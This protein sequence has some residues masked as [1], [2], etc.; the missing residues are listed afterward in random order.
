MAVQNSLSPTVDILNQDTGKVITH[1]SENADRVVNLSQT[2]IVRINASPET[3]NFY[4]RQGN[5]L[6]VHMKD[7]TTVRYQNF[8]HLDAEGQHSELIF[9]D[10]KGVHHALFPFAS[11]AGPAVAEAIT[12]TM[13]DTTLG[14]LT[15]AEGLTTLQALGGIAAIGGI[16][17]VA[18]AA[19]NSG[20]GGGGNDDNN[21]GGD[22]GGGDNGGGD[23]G[24]GDN[25]GGD[26]GGGDNGGGETPDPAEIALDP[27]TDDNI[28]NGSEVLQNQVISGTVDAA[29]AGR[30]ITVTLNGN[31][32]TGVVGADGSWSVT[33]PASALQAL[34]QGLNTITVTLVDVNGNTVTQT[35]DINV[36][37]VAPTLQLT[38]F[39][40]GVL[41]GEQAS[42]TQILRGSTGVAEEGQTVTVTLNGKTYTATVGADGSWQAAIPSADLLALQNG[43]QY[44]L[45]VSIT[46]LAGNTTTSE[47]RFTVNFDR[48]VLA[49]DDFTGDNVLNGS[50]LATDQILSGTTQ[51]IAAGTVVTVTLNGQNYYATVGGDGS[52]QVTI[53]S[54]DLQALANGSAT[55]TVSVP[56]GTGA[57][58]TVTDTLT[59]D[60]TVPSV[61][62]AILSTD[63]YLNAAEAT[64]PLE[65]RGFTTVTGPGAQVT[66]TFNDKTYTAV[67]DSAGNWS[68]LIPPADLATLPDGPR[69]VTATVT[70]GSTTATTD[71]VINVEINDLPAPTIVTPFGD[72]ALSAADLQQNQT[73]SG[74]TGVSGSG[75]TVTVQIGNQ[76]YTT[77][78]GTDGGWSVTIP[79]S[80]LQALPPGQTPIVVTATD[81]AGNSASATSS[82]NIDTTPPALSLYAVTDDGKLNAQ[83]LT[84]SQVLSGNSSEAGQTVTVTLNGK[85]YTTTTGSDGNWQVTLPAA[86]LGNL[87]PGAN[88]IVVTTTDAAGNTAQITDSLNVKTA[89]PSVTVTPFT[90]DNALDAAEIKTAQPLQGSVTNAEPGS[91]VTV[92]IGAWNTTATV[93]AAGNWRVDVPAVVLQGLANGDNNIQVSVTDTWNQT[94]T[95]QAP[96]TV[97]TAA[98]GVAI[99]IIADDDFINRT[100]AD[101]PL[102]I[103]G[104]SAG[105]PANTE[106][107]VTLNGITYTATVDANGNWQTTVPAADLQGLADGNYEVTATAQQGGVSDSHTLTVIINNLPDT[108]IDPLFT[109]GTLSQAEAGVDQVLT[110]S[111]GVAGAGQSVT[112]T[113]NGQAYQG[114]VDA[115]GNWSVT[116][117]SGALDSLTGN[118]SPVPLQIVVRDAAGNSQTTTTDFIVDVDAPTLTINPFAQDDALNITE[119]GQAQAFSGVATGA[120]QGD[121]IVV[122][123]NGK[124]YNTTV[125]GANG[126]WSVNIPAADLQAL[127]N[128]QAQFSVTVTDAA[129]NTSTA[130]K[131][132]TVAVDPARA[133]LLTIEPVGGDGVIDAGER[134]SGVTL[135]GTT[136]NVT[137]GQTVTITLGDDTFTGVV[138]SAGRW[139]VN[140]PADALAGLANGTYT[141]TAVV[142]DAAGN[143]VSLD[144]GFSVNTDISALTVSPVTGDNRVSLDDIAGGLVLSGSSVNFAPQ[145]TLTITLNGK[146]YTATTGADGSWSVT[147]PRADAL[148]ISDGKATL[149]V[150]GTD[151]N[152][153]VIS[154]SQSFT[155]ITT[156]L[157]EV[158]L[159][160]PFT[161]GIISAAEVSAGGAL[162]G[163]T[164]VT[165]AGQTVTVQ[166]GGNTYNAV[167]DSSGNW[168]V[169]LPPSALQGLTEGTTP[170]VVTATDAVGNQ[171]TSQSTVTVDLTAPVLTV[172]D[173]TADNIV[174][175]TEAAQPLTI[176][177]SA[178]PYDPQ[179]PQTV[180]VQIGGQS[181]SALVQ[182][183]GTWSVTL[184][185]GALTTLPDGPVSVTA[186]VSDAAGNTSSEKVS[187]TLDASQANAP[188]VAVNT[189]ATDNFI[190]ATE[191]QSPLQITGTTTRVEPG[192]TVTV[193]LNGQTYT[194]EVQPNGTWSVAVPA[195]ALAQVADGQQT[196]GVT[197]TD[198]SGNQAFVQYPVTFAAQPGSQPQVTLNAIAGDDIINSQ[199]SGQPLD[200][201]GTST[202]LAPGT[203]VS[204]VFNN[205]TYTGT[206]GANGQWSV[207][208]PASA[209]AGLQDGAYTVTATARDAAQNTATDSSSV[210]V[211]T[212]TPA[213]DING[214]S[215][216]DDAILN[217][218]E[219][220]TD[221]TLG[222]TTTAGATVQLVVGTQTLTTV[223]GTDGTWSITIPAAQ[224]QA[225]DNGPQDLTLTVTTPTGNT[226]TVPLPVTVGNDTV[227]TLAIGTVFTDGLINLSEIQNGGVISGT[228]TGLPEGTSIAITL[229]GITLNG[230]VGAGGAWQITAGADA[231]DALQ[232][233]QYTLTVTAQDQYGNP[234]TAGVAVDV[235]RTPPTA[236]VPDL[237]FGDGTVNQSEAA[238]GQQLTGTTG[239]TGAGQTVQISI[240]GGQPITGTVDNNGN[241]TVSLTPAQ[242]S[243]LADG[244]HT[245]SVTVSDRAGN[246]ATSPEATFTVYADP[247][248]TP[249]VTEP[250]TNGVLNA[251]EAAAGATLNGTTGLPADRIG[252]VMVSLNN[253]AMVQATVDADGNWSLPLTPA[254]LQA[255]PDGTIPITVI[256]TDT[257]GNTNTGTTSFDARINAVP[258]ATLNTPFIDGA[259]NNAEAGVAQTITGSTGVSGAGQ[260]VEI[261]LNGT[262]YTGAVLE[263]GDWS[264]SLPPSAFTGLT[265]GST[266]N[267]Q[268]NV[269]D[270]YGNTDSAPGSFQVETQLPT[271]AATTLFGDNAILNISEANGPLTLT[272]TTGVTGDNQYVTVTIDVNGTT[273]VANVD[274]AG[275]WSLPLPAGALSGLSPGQ[276]TLTIVAQDNFGNSQE[277]EVPFQA[278][279]TPPQVALT[280]PLFGDGYVNIAEAGAASTISGTLTSDLPNGSQ[281]SVT[282]GNKT[283]GPDRVTVTGNTWTLSLTAADW[284][285]VPNGLQS[286]NVSLTDGAGNT[287]TTTAPLYVS[288][289]AP[290]LTIDAPFGG[291]GLSG[292]ES[293]QTQT[294]TGTV[295]NV[296]P[297]QTITVTLAGQTFT[298][299]V[300]NGN[301]WSLQLSP[302]QLA[303]LANGPEQITATVTDKAG[304]VASA[305]AVN[306]DIDTTPPAVA[307]AINP[308]A[309]D[310]IINAG[311]LGDAVTISGTTLGGVSQ[312]TVQINGTAVGT[313]TVQPDGSWS[314]DVPA[315]Q[316]PNQGNYTI[317]ATTDGGT[318]ATTNVTVT[319]DTVPP[320][321]TVG[322]IAGDNVIDASEASQPLVLNGTAS[323]SEAGRQVT[324]TFNG[325][326]YYAVVGADG[327]WSVTVPQ[328]A[329]NGLSDGTYPVTATLTDA[330]GNVDTDTRNITLDTTGPLLT[331]DAAGVPAVLNTVN[332]AGG[333]LLQGTGEPGQTVTL[334]LGPLTETATVD[335]NGNWQYTFPQLDLT[336]LTDGAQ[337]INISS[338]D[339]QGNTSTNNVALNVALNKG[340]G[341]LVDDLFGGD[342]ILN[343]AE[344]LV[345]QTLTGQ[346]SGD[347]RGA[348]VT[349]TLVGTDVNIPLNAL[350]GG[351]GRISV[352]FPPSLWQGIVDNT[353]QVQLNVTDA[354]GN[355]TNKI[356]DIN[357]ALTDVPVVSQVLVGTDN[358]IN[359]AESTVN[360]TI[361]GVVSNAENVSSIIVNFAGQRLTAVV[362]DTGRWT[363]TL[364][365]TLLGAL[366]DG[367]AALQVV[368][369]DNA[370]NVNTTGATFNV[371]INNLPTINIGSLFGDGTLSIPELLQGT[372]SGT[373]TGLAGQ[374]LTIQIGSTPAFTATVGPNGVWS[375]NLP[376]AVQS[377]LTGIATGNQTVTVTASDV[378]GN[379]ASAT[380][381][382]TLDLLAPALSS[383]S[384]FGDGL[385]NAADALVS[386]TIS[387][388]VTNATAGSSVS[389]ALGARTFTGT[390]GTGGRFTIQ[391]NP[392]DLASLAEGSLTPRV[393]ITTPDGNTTT[394]NGTPVV[395]GIT[396]L[397]T[398]AI[399]TLFGGDGWLNAAEANAGQVISG[400]SNLTSGTVTLNVGGSTFTAAISNG[401]W[402]VNV[403]AATLK[404]L[405]DGTLTVSASVT[406]PVGNVATGSQ[407]VNAI[408]QALPQVAVN[409]IFGD[410]ILSLSDLLSP[411]LISGTATNL[412]AGSALTVK[413]GAL[414]FNTTVRADGTWQVSVPTTSLQGLTD[415]P[416]NVTV[417]A[418][419]AAGNTASGSNGLTVN[420]GA[421]P[422]LAITSLFGDNGLNATDILSAQTISGTST[423]AVG[424]QV[425]VSLG[426]KNYVTTV[427]N[428]GTWQLSVPKTDLS[429]LLDGTLTVN[430][431]VTNPAG[432]SAN[433]S[434]VL[435]VITHSLPTVSLT[436]L[437]GNDG[438]LNV[439]EAG[440]GQ[441]ISGKITGAADGATVKV[442]LGTNTYN[443]TVAS[444][445]TWSLPVSSSILDGLSNGAL[446]VGVSVTDK[447]GNV[448]STSSDVTVKLTTPTLT[449]NPLTSLNPLALLSTGLTLRGGS[450]NLAPGSVVHLS[451]LNGT[452]NTTAITDSNG[453]WSANLGLGLNILQLLSL[454]SVL[455]IYA[456]DVAGNTGYLNV[457]LGGQIIS[458]TPPATFA[459]ASV[460]HEASLFALADETSQTA[461]TADSQQ[462]AVTAKIAAVGAITETNSDSGSTVAEDSSSVA[463]GYTIGGVSID[464][465]DG[466]S[467]SGESVQGSSGSDTIHL[468]SLGFASLDGGAGTDTLVIDGVNLK[469]DLT[470]LSG[471]VQH[472]EIFDLGKSGT[473]SL[474]LDLHQALTIT[475]KPEDDLIVKGVNGDQVNLVK[476]GSDI[477]EVSGQR[478]VDG[479][480]F[481][482]WHNSSQ[483][484]TLGDVLIQH[485]LHVN[486]V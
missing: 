396:T 458:T 244:S 53:P 110:G 145:T 344:S 198:A 285:S 303:T 242:L 263:N 171:N 379:S 2:S 466:T 357:L 197:V 407:I 420:I 447:V 297:G 275:N 88:P 315:T 291:D 318:P 212:T 24:G 31:T 12:P 355:V 52:W 47:T 155:I 184:P 258:D 382:L 478:E 21:G 190:N 349:A 276:H 83:E 75:Q 361:S 205:V 132:I 443:A 267:F 439:S 350:V 25:G 324:V 302:A 49:V 204:V 149:T 265:P 388:V 218:S 168:S 32:Y 157:P 347:Y 320:V 442:T 446:K 187:L 474:T 354:F 465:A 301:T 410:G 18:I 311:E 166:L 238:L 459:A 84:T 255:L 118:D 82:V 30:T 306:V 251:T 375:V 257:A 456:T 483:T 398:V 405:Q 103:R 249:V 248:P 359:F 341:V 365:S 309:G 43:Q 272:G 195:T 461:T 63:D 66:V 14:A 312:V 363:A 144:R 90:G 340:F 112:V 231:L 345:T 8:F 416:L 391:L 234:A 233:G 364:P 115:N 97:D 77:T 169:T 245:I 61:S 78:A 348:T 50:E 163:T 409:P 334:R 471:Q 428:D 202:N 15:G 310:N 454:S 215:F 93:D 211:D 91:V 415:G 368:V 470:A 26:N 331:V 57:P 435:N 221:Q 380:G 183:D 422:T 101:S 69:T 462:S 152:G 1:Y 179:N 304:N 227:P 266:Q 455:N 453:N 124:T 117:P 28:L 243:A 206:T 378:N 286:V 356:I 173:I 486:M 313:A 332:A 22:N 254:Q 273:Y 54:G 479:V 307:V 366:P 59:V 351:D 445:G 203:I 219:S 40:D 449:F 376:E 469:L 325:E 330:A 191:A 444:D 352:D 27:L 64:Q 277:I 235:L 387:G 141:V 70:S 346:L 383:L 250:F 240:D 139:E 460:E 188:L 89:L 322:T 7:G 362:D 108:T 373:T 114:T 128:G 106:I 71:R 264:V 413:L 174:N 374:T 16:A 105:L 29:N 107:T 158:T 121:A 192:Q 274:S 131:P 116:L 431:S 35:A 175:A 236:A 475:D 421:L 160:T 336:T 481:D 228:S 196:I 261:V 167:V 308:V 353:L 189:V 156:D 129:G 401:A 411:Q 427:G 125:T 323:T 337:V 100:E 151:E 134:A 208:V 142:S 5:D 300:Q 480:Q 220:L 109:D 164:G 282:I 434:G 400:T 4:E 79:A 239:L 213:T 207:T 290:T 222:G 241:W 294:I 80:Q 3:V 418:R 293:Q 45:S 33:L 224:L 423:N 269:S 419:D 46:D 170:L 321:V 448:N 316:F 10:D 41:G 94:T 342:G 58:L 399:N 271:P 113:L 13:A 404:G 85:T 317:V 181:Y 440:S 55:L 154:G 193:T 335:Q 328:S 176:S 36:D 299:T 464:L 468:A 135:S 390:V 217:V 150:S 259:L 51:N 463:G 305:P 292:A 37:T 6:I 377:A 424:S 329:L 281:I 223:A 358:L 333:L 226:S 180:V 229:G 295:T 476:G 338:T 473:N 130:T 126:E 395:V 67:L 482:V 165:G 185:A 397:P 56:N 123:L 201:T 406:D 140:L 385:L 450:A 232:N 136:T 72:G 289:A 477:W 425:T 194:G 161:D 369:T 430:A 253:G 339:A 17:G 256:V 153:A 20:G 76:T 34:P 283:F 199:E 467:Q 370:G 485:G 472:I 280:Q 284:T 367:Q 441:T 426:G 127:P 412:A 177:G 343:V 386:Q 319:L 172:N 99:S 44:V 39:T 98:S 403:P 216:L 42:T 246:T 288:L 429:G 270:A 225:L 137:A 327:A 133:P 452:V 260:T 162:S 23:N 214:G 60:R 360:Q 372:L 147:V 186:T 48:P 120:A 457:G 81:G 87:S 268:V 278:A 381:S 73:L 252:T 438:Y 237:L 122:T 74:N 62:I 65:I 230:K 414:T 146:Q 111:T 417:T 9:E 38:P 96:I 247:L 138:D 182:S 326:T 279:L 384:V 436:S 408:V 19:S 159:N 92:A 433:T 389:V 119:A 287:A 104:T 11:E 314:L 484:N 296:E 437:F 148:D 262:T 68:V 394:V 371:A 392:T 200:I 178:T 102:T 143:S 86:D 451:L 209:L 210:T 402:S 432:N 393:T 298:T 95:I